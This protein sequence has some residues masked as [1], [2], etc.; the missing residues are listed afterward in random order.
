MFTPKELLLLGICTEEGSR[1]HVLKEFLRD[2]VR[3]QEPYYVIATSALEAQTNAKPNARRELLVAT[4]HFLNATPDIMVQRV[5]EICKD[6]PE[7][8]KDAI[9][10][11]KKSADYER[12]RA[13]VLEEQVQSM[14]KRCGVAQ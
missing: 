9:L 4:R 2:V 12:R 5:T 10:R 3:R 6:D 13:L 7:L 14:R 11:L 8:Y 1:D